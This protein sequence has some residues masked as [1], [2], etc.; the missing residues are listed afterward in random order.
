MYTPFQLAKKYI[1]YYLSAANGNGHGVHSPFVFD[2]IKNVLRDNKQYECYREIEAR[3]KL[4]LNG[5]SVIEVEDFGA[6]S[7][8]LK[9]NKRAVKNIAASSLK[10]RKF[11]Q[12]LFRIVQYYKP[13]NIL[14]LG[15]S[16]G[17]TTCYL[18][19]GNT[20]ATVFTCEGSSSIAAIAQQNF[21]ALQLD[22]IRVTE[23][24]FAKTL[25]PVLSGIDTID[26]AFVDG[27]H[28]KEPT[29]EYFSALLSHSNPSSIF[30]FDDVHWSEEMEAAWHNI[31]QHPSVTLTIDL[32]FIGLVFI[33]PD[34]KIKQHFTIRF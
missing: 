25:Q 33:N 4:L 10:P 19:T 29:L 34:F 14:E 30:I 3:R 22:N 13:E 11:A 27:N 31:Q 15:T 26:L 16:L 6:G 12:L 28:R 24:N 8:K 2:F 18:A 17:V 5:N 1:R 9:S 32:F 21:K 20:A 23:G 7:G